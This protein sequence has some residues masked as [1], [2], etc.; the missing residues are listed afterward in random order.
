MESKIDYQGDQQSK[1][2]ILGFR[3]SER[4]FQEQR[5]REKEEER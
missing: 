1:C 5:D 3:S 4:S 2:G